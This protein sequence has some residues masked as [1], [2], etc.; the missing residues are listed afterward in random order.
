MGA[1]FSKSSGSFISSS[2]VDGSDSRRNK[3]NQESILN[4]VPGI[5]AS[6]LHVETIESSSSLDL[7][8]N[9][10]SLIPIDKDEIADRHSYSAQKL[11]IEETNIP[12]IQ[13]MEH[14][15][16]LLCERKNRTCS[17][18]GQTQELEK[19]TVS[20]V[21]N[22]NQYVSSDIYYFRLLT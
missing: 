11:P 19:L 17:A 22:L 12:G 14:E 18:V 8:N 9:K 21:D 13:L 10:N 1:L 2:E 7:N 6:D 16:T 15:H 20:K 3:S 5:L 4:I